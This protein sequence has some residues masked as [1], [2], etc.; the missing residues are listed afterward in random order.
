MRNNY[1]MFSNLLQMTTTRRTG[2]GRIVVTCRSFDVKHSDSP[3]KYN[4]ED[5][6]NVSDWVDNVEKNSQPM[7]TP[8]RCRQPRRI[9]IA[10]LPA[11]D[12]QED[13]PTPADI[14]P[15]RLKMVRCLPQPIL[16]QITT[17]TSLKRNHRH[18]LQ[19]QR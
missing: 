2:H 15:Q 14:P 8:T 17:M 9:A 10:D 1:H 5:I 11:I 3:T 16:M 18:L 6:V 12:V 7:K 19:L 13:L 4:G